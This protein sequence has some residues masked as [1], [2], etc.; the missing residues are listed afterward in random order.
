MNDARCT[1]P[2]GLLCD[3][4]VSTAN[5][6]PTH[7]AVAA[8]DLRLTYKELYDH[9]CA[10]ASSLCELT[11]IK[12]NECVGIMLYKCAWMTVAAHAIHLASAAYVP[13]DPSLPVD[14]V[15]SICTDAKISVMCTN[16]ISQANCVDNVHALTLDSLP[17]RSSTSLPTPLQKPTDWAYVIFTSGSTGRPKGVVLNHQGPKNTCA[18]VNATY[19]ILG[20]DVTFGISSLGFDLSV[21]DLFGSTLASAALIYPRQED[22]RSPAA[23]LSL[24]RKEQ[25]TVWN[26]APAL[27]QLL[28]DTAD[29]GERL[30]DLRLVMLSGDWVP[31]CAAIPHFDTSP[32]RL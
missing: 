3:S 9:A 2:E 18:D 26:S 31:P 32:D 6:A 14:R 19:S 28:I 1:I 4:L 10:V 29:K 22:T 13:I 7:L 24:L 30:S 20:T 16:A 8:A 27:M 25:V 11:A 5:Q 12:V 21:F 15:A 17:L 23:W